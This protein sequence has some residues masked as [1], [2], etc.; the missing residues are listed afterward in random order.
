MAKKARDEIR[1]ELNEYLAEVKEKLAQLD[2]DHNAAKT[3]LENSRTNYENLIIQFNNDKDNFLA[4][5]KSIIEQTEEQKNAFNNQKSQ[6]FETLQKETQEAIE[7]QTTLLEEKTQ[8]T[9]EDTKNRWFTDLKEWA[10][11]HNKDKIEELDAFIKTET[12][13]ATNIVSQ[14]I[15]SEASRTLADQKSRKRLYAEIKL[16]VA[17]VFMLILSWRMYTTT[18]NLEPLHLIY[19]ILMFVPFGVYIWLQAKQ[20][21]R[22]SCLRDHYHH[23]QLVMASYSAFF[24]F[25]K[26][27]EKFTEEKQV[28]MTEAMFAEVR[29][30]AA[31]RADNN[32]AERLKAQNKLLIEIVRQIP[33]IKKLADY[34][35][36]SNLIDPKDKD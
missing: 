26:N 17:L 4:D 13:K 36:L 9:Q 11:K 10:T 19:K 29:D 1:Q 23:K 22:E 5:L 35:N 33:S 15:L 18:P 21:R 27:N 24:G 16:T 25:L 20:I 12:G 7:Q 8:Q 31:N 6:L 2:V 32:E 30:N 14:D 28:E 3:N 34:P